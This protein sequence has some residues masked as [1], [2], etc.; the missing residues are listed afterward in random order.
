[1]IDEIGLNERVRAEKLR[2]EEIP[3]AYKQK[4]D[5]AT[6]RAVAKTN[7]LLEYAEPFLALTLSFRP[8]SLI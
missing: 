2:A 7:I 4:L 1:M 3:N 6:F 8:R 5:F